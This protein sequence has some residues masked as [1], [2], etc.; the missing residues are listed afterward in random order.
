MC[1][2]PSVSRNSLNYRRGCHAPQLLPTTW[3]NPPGGAV[4]EDAQ[5]KAGCTATE[6]GRR[7]VYPDLSAYWKKSGQMLTMAGSVLTCLRFRTLSTRVASLISGLTNNLA[8]DSR[9]TVQ[10]PVAEAFE[11]HLRA[12]SCI[13]SGRSPDTLYFC[14]MSIWRPSALPVMTSIHT[15]KGASTTMSGP[16]HVPS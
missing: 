3:S 6:E 2:F 10:Q 15:S 16:S 8:L 5:E 9:T 4:A 11:L 13:M 1:S 14:S 12:S 7:G